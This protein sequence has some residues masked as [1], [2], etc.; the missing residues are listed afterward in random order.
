[1]PVMMVRRAEEEARLW[2][3]ANVREFERLYS[4]WLAARATVADPD[5]PEDDESGHE[6]IDR[7]D[8]AARALLMAPAVL[9][10]MVWQKW[11]V[12]D[13]WVS[14]D[15][16]T[17]DWTDNRIIMALGVIK[18]DIVTFGLQ[19]RRIERAGRPPSRS[20][21]GLTINHGRPCCGRPFRPR[22]CIGKSLCDTCSEV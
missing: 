12:L 20:G 21:G 15:D 19:G 6:A 7:R 9:P 18:A 2:R 17:P 1:M 13:Y 10:W 8:A 14:A 22:G 3:S 16:D 11:E 5:L 4:R